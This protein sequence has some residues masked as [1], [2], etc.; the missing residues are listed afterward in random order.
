MAHTNGMES[1][2]GMMKRGYVGTCHYMSARHPPRYVGEFSGRPN[3]REVDTINQM[4]HIAA[5]RTG[6]LLIYR[7]LVANS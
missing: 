4:Q 3:V 1:F 5:M 7:D 2:W 6:N